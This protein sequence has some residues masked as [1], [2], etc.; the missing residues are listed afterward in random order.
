MKAPQRGQVLVFIALVMTL[1]L[2]PLA[3]YAIDAATLGGAAA[4]LQAAT[5]EAV[6]AA[7]QQIDA[8]VFRSRG[9]L[10]IDH[11]AA[12]S[13]ALELLATEAPRAS[14]RSIRF[15]GSRLTLVASESV[16]LPF[17]FFTERSIVLTAT[18]SAR[19]AEGYERPS[20]R[21]PLPISTF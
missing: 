11:A 15:Q 12:R 10:T 7:A 6:M 19:L 21:L 17:D 3:A 9:E 18:A 13:T 8:E 16:T 1:V 14:V 2:L 20:S 5:A 4:R